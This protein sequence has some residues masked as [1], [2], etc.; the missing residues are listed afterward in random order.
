MLLRPFVLPSMKRL[1]TVVRLVINNSVSQIVGLTPEQFS[2]LKDELS[3][4]E[5]DF[6]Y[7]SLTPRFLNRLRE[8]KGVVTYKDAKGIPRPVLNK[9]FRPFKRA[10][11]VRDAVSR[12]QKAFIK[13][14]VAKKTTLISKKGEFPSGLLTMAQTWLKE[15]C[16]SVKVEDM[17]ERPEPTPGMFRLNLGDLKPYPE[18]L[19]A[20]EAAVKIGRG[21]IQACTGFGKSLVLAVLVNRL[22][23]RTLILVP[24]LNLKS[25]LRETFTKM[26]GGLEN[27]TI[28][29][30]DSPV[31]QKD[32]AYDL[33]VIDEGHHSACRTIQKLNK[34]L[35]N[36]I[37]HRFFLSATPYRSREAENI[38]LQSV[39]GD[40]IY[41]VPYAKARDKGYVVP[42]E[43]YFYTLPKTKNPGTSWPEVY[44]RC[45]VENEYRN[46]LIAFLMKN[47][48]EHKQSTL[49]LVKELAHGETLSGLTGAGFAN[50]ESD[51][52][53]TLMNWFAN[54]DLK[55]L[56]ATTG[57]AG[58]G[59][60]LRACSWV[61]IAGLGKSRNA[62]AQQVGR[63]VRRF[64]GKEWG[65]VIL[66]RD[67]S[68]KWL[69]DHFQSECRHLKEEFGVVA[70]ELELPETL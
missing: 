31:I 64:P 49:T 34:R 33:L 23:L 67:Q 40:M 2:G 46:K 60:D 52:T 66:F 29:N 5:V 17:R 56:I 53:P 26:F 68:S 59:S 35:W 19:A 8:R 32:G 50:G 16:I 43:A 44:K 45:V 41:S 14:Y 21:T 4:E 18:Q 39:T 12:R 10:Q 42:V 1:S 36:D 70:E 37:Y 11:D 51:E 22:Q 30:Y 25:Q 28:E 65:R 63:C 62:F 38:I 15:N 57:V 24:N 55:S 48:H 6:G 7:F 58:E 13:G 20:V 54:G 61:I 3:S 47:L 27:V 69:E 9:Q